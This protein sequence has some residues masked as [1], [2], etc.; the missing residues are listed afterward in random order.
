MLIIN[1][2]NYLNNFL[3]FIINQLKA[4][5]PTLELFYVPCKV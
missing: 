3:N 1:I 4:T 5:E 2:N